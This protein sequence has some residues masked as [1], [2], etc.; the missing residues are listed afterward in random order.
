MKVKLILIAAI[1]LACLVSCC[2]TEKKNVETVVT[3]TAVEEPK[4][5]KTVIVARVKVKE[6]KEADFL[7]I[8]LPL[9]EATHREEGNLYYEL[10]QSPKQ[11]T[12]FIFYEE[13]VDDQAFD[14]HAN[15]EH[16]KA[17]AAAVPELV[18]E[19]MKIDRF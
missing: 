8:A 16:F 14:A 1:G 13:Y 6:G 18:A 4:K 10:Y 15:S 2:K 19:E 5:E 17:F 7:K 9:V 3:E 11:A 12:V